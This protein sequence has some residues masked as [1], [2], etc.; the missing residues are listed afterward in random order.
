MV[1]MRNTQAFQIK[2]RIEQEILGEVGFEQFVVFR[3]ENIE[4]QRIAA[5]LDRRE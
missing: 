3:L 1:E 4:R 5:L 2:L